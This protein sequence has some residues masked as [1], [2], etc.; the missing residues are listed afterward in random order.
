MAPTQP[1]QQSRPV[2][3][4]AQFRR[5]RDEPNKWVEQARPGSGIAWRVGK[6]D[7]SAMKAGDPVVYWRTI[8]KGHDRGGIVGTGRVSSPEPTTGPNGVSMIGT[9]IAEFYDDKPLGRDEVIQ[10]TGL[11]PGMW[12]FSLF[13]LPAAVAHKM[14]SYLSSNGLRSLFQVAASD[15]RY[16]SAGE[17]VLL[18]DEPELNRDML[19][20][21]DLAFM[22]AARLNLVW[23][24]MNDNGEVDQARGIDGAQ[25][26]SPNAPNKE[27]N[28]TSRVSLDFESA[29]AGRAGFVVHIDAPWGGGKTSFANYLT[30]ILNPYSRPGPPPAWLQALPLVNEQNWPKA[31]RRPWHIAIFNAWQHQHLNPPWWCFYQ[32]IRK[33][34]FRSLAWEVNEQAGNSRIPKPRPEYGYAGLPMRLVIGAENWVRETSWRL[35]TPNNLILLGIAAPTLSIATYAYVSGWFTDTGKPGAFLTALATLLTGGLSFVWA[36]FSTLTTSLV[37]GTPD[38]A[39]NYSLGAGDPLERFRRHFARTMRHLKRPVLVVVDDI[40]RCEPQ[41]VVELVR[42]IQTILRSP[43][44]V[45]LLLGDR[46]WIEQAFAEVHKA[47]KPIDV[48]GEHSFGGRFVEKAIQLSLVLPAMP[49]DER[50]VYVKALLGLSSEVKVDPAENLDEQQREDVKQSIRELAE[51]PDPMVRDKNAADIRERVKG[52]AA[53]SDEVKRVVVKSIDR[54][55]ALRSA[56]DKRVQAATRHRLEPIANVLP[57]NPRQIK[58]IINAIAL[59]QEVARIRMSVQPE[60]QRWRQLALWIVLM[61][62]W[63]QTGT[64]LA[65]WPDLVTHVHDAKRKKI[66]NIRPEPIA[67]SWTETIRANLEIM[68]LLDFPRYG[69]MHDQLVPEDWRDS[70]IDVDAIRELNIIIPPTSGKPFQMSGSKDPKRP[71]N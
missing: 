2:V 17:T 22:L 50:S 21:A 5:D 32:A 51:T 26:E 57:P 16:G 56:A 7:L 59:Y 67:I 30:H 49:P 15:S 54:E 38:A 8:S 46:N 4:L 58:R 13:Q 1:Q 19:N 23:D 36:T 53:V 31:F 71:L 24:E 45:F 60:T 70:T 44:V 39:R 48:G 61:T 42:G 68:A 9:E 47:M 3:W 33:Q 41:F 64:R 18:H 10:A 55:M 40:D 12:Q 52:F 69:A 35:F 20:R 27:P 29:L 25:V 43:R 34:V 6:T 66:I 28:S 62:E 63:P 37:P 65:E 11:E 14:D